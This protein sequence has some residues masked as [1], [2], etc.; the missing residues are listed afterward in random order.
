MTMT[1]RRFGPLT[2]EVPT[3]G[4]G[5]WQMEDDD[6][7]AATAAIHR[8]L[9]L[10]ATHVDTAEMYGAGRV[11][12]LVGAAL[13]G[14][15]DRAFLVSKVLPKNAS[16]D[17]TIRACERSLR[18]L[19]T[20]HLDGYLLHWRGEHP[21]AET[22]AGF[23][24]LR[25]QGKIRAWGVSNFDAGD[26][27][28]ALAIAGPGR[29]ACNQV[30]YHLGERTIEHAVVPWCQA[31]DVAVVGYSPFGSGDFPEPSSPGG[32]VLAEVARTVGASARQVAL[33]FL[34]R[35]GGFV[36]PKASQA[37]HVADN[38]G[39]AAIALDDVVVAQ[40]DRAFPRGR[41]H[42]LQTI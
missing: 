9:E 19:G 15:R 38:T 8:A 36:I 16:R 17:G 5:T 29:I 37:A 40:L 11:E 21:L 35:D 25:E 39:A 26:L 13:A 2:V 1:Q 24:T 33:A 10:G 27:A 28:D 7:A 14:R 41:W 18:R 42:G 6:P 4:I 3:I 30:L 34:L 31:H 20:D 23:E 12:E 32:R 22:I